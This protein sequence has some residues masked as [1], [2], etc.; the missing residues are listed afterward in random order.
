MQSQKQ[1]NPQVI[2]KLTPAQLFDAL[3]A[4]EPEYEKRKK[5][6]KRQP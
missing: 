6:S 1:D 4:A 5:L 3:V 2:K